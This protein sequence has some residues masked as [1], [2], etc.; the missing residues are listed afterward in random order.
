MCVGLEHVS[1]VEDEQCQCLWVV[2]GCVGAKYVK[3]N[4]IHCTYL[5]CGCGGSG[6]GEQAMRPGRGMLHDWPCQVV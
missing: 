3:M 4:M 1:C 2:R 6:A 5:G